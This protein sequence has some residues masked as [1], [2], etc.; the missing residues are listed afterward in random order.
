MCVHLSFIQATLALNSKKLYILYCDKY[1]VRLED[2]EIANKLMAS[3]VYYCPLQ[4]S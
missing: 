1:N 4:S 2:L 3:W